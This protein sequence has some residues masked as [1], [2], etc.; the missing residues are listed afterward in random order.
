MHDIDATFASEDPFVL[1][2]TW[3]ADAEKSE[4]NDPNAIALATV[5]GEGLP[6]VRIVLLKEIEDVGFLFYTNYESAKGRE[7]AENSQAAFVMHWKTLGRQIRVRGTV[8]KENG[9]KAD[10]YFATRAAESRIGAWASAQ[11]RPLASREALMEEVER[12]KALQ[13]PDPARP[14]H[15]GGYRIRPVEMEFWS[16]GAHR[17]HDRFQWK[18]TKDGK[19]EVRRLNP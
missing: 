9:P 14:D 4:P 17:L 13:G 12:V 1:A 6:N 2:K 3:L 18:A 15:W 5:D 11:S 19:W 7:L 10:A 8:E 16:D